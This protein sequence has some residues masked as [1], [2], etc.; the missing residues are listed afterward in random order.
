MPTP[1]NQKSII[2]C[3]DSYEDSLIKGYLYHGSFIEG[4]KFDN[5]M[6]LIFTI[7]G[8]LKD[9]EGEVEFVGKRRFTVFGQAEGEEPQEKSGMLASFKVRILFRQNASWQGSVA[10][11]EQNVEE[12]FRSAL[13][14][15]ML[16]DSAMPN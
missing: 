15:I 2:I 7:E 9:T 16:I 12:P 5:L 11:L 10:W 6:Q 8:V 13:E 4:K 14:M 1:D 3:V